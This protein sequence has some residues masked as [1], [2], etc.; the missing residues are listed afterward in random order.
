MDR[1]DNGAE[2]VTKIVRKNKRENIVVVLMSDGRAWERVDR[3]TKKEK[4]KGEYRY[5]ARW[6]SPKDP[7]SKR[8][9][10]ELFLNN[11]WRQKQ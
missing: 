1:K 4:I 9:F 11:G 3:K 6:G 10:L 7:N 2:K 5:L 8:L